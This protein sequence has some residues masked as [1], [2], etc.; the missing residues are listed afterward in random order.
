MT[1]QR[2]YR[3]LA[4]VLL[5]KKYRDNSVILSSENKLFMSKKL[6]MSYNTYSSLLKESLELGIIKPSGK[7]FQ[8]IGLI[9]SIGKLEL[10]E[11][12]TVHQDFYKRAY[13]EFK[14]YKQVYEELV[15][16]VA[17]HNYKM[18]AYNIEQ[19]DILFSKNKEDRK[20]RNKILKKCCKKAAKTGICTDDYLKNLK[21]N[22]K[23]NI[24]SGK[25]HLGKVLGY[26]SSS[27]S[28][29]LRKMH[30]DETITRKVNYFFIEGKHD[31]I[32]YGYLINEFNTVKIIPTS[33]GYKGYLGSIITIGRE[34][35]KVGTEN[36][37]D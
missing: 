6:G 16:L 15:K 29:W 36:E 17:L 3:I 18:Q 2:R 9:D 26:S 37:K 11:Y 33:L 28:N 21:V 31:P 12:V 19:K 1:Q 32:S 8:V 5:L 4:F 20:K 13:F 27:G 14:N 35:L 22:R 7:H 30:N 24:V 23:R 10:L 34:E 25:F